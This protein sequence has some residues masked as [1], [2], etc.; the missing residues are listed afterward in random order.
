M[1]HLVPDQR[2]DF[3]LLE[4][5]RTGIHKP[6]L[7]ALDAVHHQP[8][9]IDGE[10][11]L[12]IAPVNRISL[13]QVNTFP[14]QVQ[15]AANTIRSLTSDLTAQGWQS[16]DFWDQSQGRYTDRFIQ[17]IAQ[18]YIPNASNTEAAILEA[19]AAEK[20]LAA[21]ITD[22]NFD[23]AQVE[24]C[25][26]TGLDV[27]SALLKF[28]EQIPNRYQGLSCQRHALLE[29]LRIWRKLDTQLL[30][31]ATLKIPIPPAPSIPAQ[32]MPG[33]DETSLDPPLLQF[34]QTLPQ[35]YSGYPHQ[36]EALIRLVQVWQQLAS[37]ELAIAALK[38]VPAKQSTLQLLD[39]ALVAFVQRL[40]MAY[41]KQREQRSALMETFRLWHQLDSRD[42]A[43]KG[44]G[45]DP[46]VLTANAADPTFMANA[47][48]LL[49]R[50][51]LAFLR[52]LPGE[53][54]ETENQRQALFRLVQLWQGWT[55][56]DHTLQFLLV[57]L[58]R[59]A[60][61]DRHSPDVPPPP[62]P[63]PLPPRPV[64]W[65]PDNIQLDLAIVPSGNFTWAE[66]TRGGT[67]MPPD[68]TTVDAIIRIAHLAQ[69]ARDR[70]GRPFQI[71][72]W[73]C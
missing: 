29:A 15:Y 60:V 55:S 19:A 44:L 41:R 25:M 65:Q 5:V 57:N 46:Q 66:A 14:A 69:Q 30:A 37:R 26:Q 59:M 6:I 12:G 13:S 70:M 72:T 31:I 35:F 8:H 1:T 21:Y 2:N 48:T 53:Y 39:S 50:E 4:A 51:L 45:V 36:R 61:A 27:D 32:S 73:Y 68:Q 52:R 56:R 11:G 7:A 34:I 40:P 67:C 62:D 10:E 42:L 16:Q 20:L 64:N 9:L 17:T 63:L 22:S 54:Q 18:G 58:Q 33:L 28:V 43:L 24:S 23:Q 3:Y 49:D 38:D 47:A 71:I